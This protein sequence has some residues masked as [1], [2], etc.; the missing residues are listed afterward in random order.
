MTAGFIGADGTPLNPIWVAEFRGF[1]FGDGYLGIVRNGYSPRNG[2]AYTTARA[3]ITV[4]DDDVAVLNDIQSKIG[5]RIIRG[6]RSVCKPIATWR[7]RTLADVATVCDLLDSGFL[8]SKK[9][10]EI[11]VVRRYLAIYIPRGKGHDPELIARLKAQRWELLA[12]LQALHS[13][14]PQLAS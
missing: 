10:A 1:F 13:Y 4:R 8:P 7:T 11:A 9:R 14:Q 12:E 6:T 2:Q 3:D 5:G